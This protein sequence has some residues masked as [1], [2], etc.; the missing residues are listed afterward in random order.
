MLYILLDGRRFASKETGHRYLC[1]KLGLF[2]YHSPNLDALHDA[3]TSLPPCRIRLRG[4]LWLAH[5][6]SARG[7]RVG[8]PRDRFAPILE[9]PSFHLCG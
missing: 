3:L 7:F 4:W 1:Q 9:F 5:P 6:A 8:E 2:R